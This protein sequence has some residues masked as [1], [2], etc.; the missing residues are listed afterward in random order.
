MIQKIAYKMLKEGKIN[1][2]EYNALEKV[3][4]FKFAGI[5]SFFKA[6]G[7][8]FTPT[9]HLAEI[10]RPGEETMTEIIRKA[11]LA[12]RIA[13]PIAATTATG[14]I[15]KELAVDPFMQAKKEQE[16]LKH[17]RELTPQLEDVDD[18]TLKDYFG[19]I[20]TFSPRTA[21]NP[22]VSGALV[23]KMVQFEGVDTNLVKDLAQIQHGEGDTGGLFR[24]MLEGGTAFMTTMSGGK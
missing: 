12:Q 2:E 3:G 4:V 18:K 19:V 9:A 8:A 1:Q 6:I 15:V 21:T 24:K 20:Q 7:K 10:I 22:L 23:N 5:G 17:L 11:P 16:S 13:V 14:A